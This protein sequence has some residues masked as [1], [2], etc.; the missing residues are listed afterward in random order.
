[1]EFKRKPKGVILPPYND[2][3]PFVIEGNKDF[4]EMLEY[5][6]REAREFGLSEIHFQSGG[7][8]R[9]LIVRVKYNNSDQPF[10]YANCEANSKQAC[11]DVMIEQAVV[12]KDYNRRSRVACS[13]STMFLFLKRILDEKE[14]GD[15]EKFRRLVK[16]FK[17]L[18]GAVWS[19]DFS[20]L[21]DF[22]IQIRDNLKAEGFSLPEGIKNLLMSPEKLMKA[23]ETVKKLA[24]KD[25]LPFDRYTIEVE[26]GDEGEKIIV[27]RKEDEECKEE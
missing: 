6:V 3:Y 12:Q 20:N 14:K 4:L 11:E 23:L 22:E 10:I 8:E 15:W 21:E 16:V 25:K 24:E 9:S 7:K 5:A 18:H 17:R 27:R 26:L 19:F 1:M 13:L 2:K